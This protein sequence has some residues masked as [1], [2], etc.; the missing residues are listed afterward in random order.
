[1]RLDKA[2]TALLVIDVLVTKGEDTLYTQDPAEQG[3]VGASVRVVDAARGG[4]AR[5]LLLRSAH[6]RTRP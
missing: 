4:V 2:R 3:L 5:H 1:M 6:P